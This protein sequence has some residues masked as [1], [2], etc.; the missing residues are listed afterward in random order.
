MI[1]W[2]AFVINTAGLVLLGYKF[3]IGWIFGITAECLWIWVAT[4]R[5]I[6]S[7]ACMSLTYIV[8]AM[9]NCRKWGVA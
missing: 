3:R 9:V 2:I 6:P 7:L 5:E 4:E 1:G 8:M